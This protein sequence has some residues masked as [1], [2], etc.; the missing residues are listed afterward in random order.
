MSSIITN[1]ASLTAQRH[2]N[3]NQTN[4]A[5]VI[6]QLSSGLRINTAAD[7]PAGYIRSALLEAQVNGLDQGTKNTQDATSEIQTALGALNQQ[8]SLLGQ[9]RS[10]ALHAANTGVNDASAIYA[11]QTQVD[12]IVNSIDQIA[13]NTS[14]GTKK[15]LN[16]SASNSGTVLDPTN[17]AAVSV[18]NTSPTGTNS[19]D[20]NVTSAATY[21]ATNNAQIVDISGGVAS[22]GNV[23]VNGVTVALTA[24][25]NAAAVVS[26]L[27]TAFTANSLGLTAST[28]GNGVKIVANNL[29]SAYSVTVTDAGGLLFSAAQNGQGTDVVGTING[30]AATGA[31]AKLTAAAGTSYAGTIVTLTTAGATATGNHAAAISVTH[32]SL[33]FQI[34]PYAADSVSV[35][36]ANM[37]ANTLGITASTPNGLMDLKTG[38]SGALISNPLGALA[39]IDQALTD[40]TTAA[41]SLGAFQIDTL[42]PKSAIN[43]VARENVSTALSNLRDVDVAQATADLTKEQILVQAATAVLAQANAA[44]QSALTL[45]RG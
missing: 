12:A 43:R 3:A 27:N 22:T 30:E 4:L 5:N 13:Q 23:V 33:N 44:P 7:D 1:V 21:A 8:V 15:L 37:S 32:G 29:G 14:F 26:K 28:Q 6:Q 24:G 9:L 36:I 20:V 2:L 18:G 40:A 16:G 17:V 25:D 42:T 31:G 11:D 41:A 39:T 45:L 35:N 19:V 10:L 34:G 38:G